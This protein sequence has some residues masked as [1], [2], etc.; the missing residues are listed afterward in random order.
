MHNVQTRFPA[1]NLDPKRI[2]GTSVAIALHVLVLMVLMLPVQMAPPASMPEET[3]M[4]I[5][6]EIKKIEPIIRV[7][8]PPREHPL[9][10]VH[11]QPVEQATPV[12]TTPSPNDTYV[13][14]THE[15]V[16]DDFSA[17]QVSAPVFAQ[18]SADVAPAPPYPLQAQKRRQSGVVMLKIRVDAQGRPMEVLVETSSGSRIL[19]EAAAK[20]VQARWHFVP[21][22]QDG[23]AVEAYALV[24]IN[25]VLD[26]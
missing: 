25:F 7:L 16:I 4:I 17:G 23:Q 1:L 19:D 8:T 18:I 26:R 12:D 3:T 9:P 5:V 11:R 2:A 15:T 14:P 24:P 22:M 10:Q 6:P 21:A 13:E 20:F